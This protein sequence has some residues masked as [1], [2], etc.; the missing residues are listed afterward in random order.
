MKTV[1]RKDLG[2]AVSSRK[3]NALPV[4]F[5]SHLTGLYSTT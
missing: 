5:N 3:S 1:T 2:G 4:D